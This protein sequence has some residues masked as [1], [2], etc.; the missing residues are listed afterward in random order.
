MMDDNRPVSSHGRPTSGHDLAAIRLLLGVAYGFAKD[1]DGL[2]DF[3][4]HVGF[5]LTSVTSAAEIKQALPAFYRVRKGVYDVARLEHELM[6][7]QPIAA[8][9]DAARMTK[10]AHAKQ[11]LT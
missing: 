2:L 9:V 1:G 11:G 8:T 4:D 10:Q 5:D 7:W 6:T 3:L